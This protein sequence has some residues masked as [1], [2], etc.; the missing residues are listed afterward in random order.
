MA[1]IKVKKNP[2]SITD[3]VLTRSNYCLFSFI[4]SDGQDDDAK[5][6]ATTGSSQ[7]GSQVGLLKLSAV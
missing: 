5:E 4:E 7:Q 3:R 2:A 6:Q 1:Y